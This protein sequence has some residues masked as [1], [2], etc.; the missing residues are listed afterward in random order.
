MNSNYE[1]M[2]SLT[3][4]TNKIDGV[5]YIFSRKSG[6]NENTLALFY[7]LDDNKP[8]SQKE[9]CD[10]WLIP[11]TTINS[12]IKNLMKKGFVTLIPEPHSKEKNILLTDSGKKYA[13]ALLSDI[14]DAEQS[15]IEATLERYSPDFVEALSY[16]SH[17]LQAAL[18][19]K[20]EE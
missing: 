16:F 6:V 4:A 11:R 13:K 3:L 8:H 10:N 9:I 7:A 2:Q 15:A 19:R 12:I 5:Y 14:Y 1:L 17:C 20:G 18:N